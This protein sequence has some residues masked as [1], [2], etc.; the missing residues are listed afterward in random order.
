MSKLQTKQKEAAMQ[1]SSKPFP[2]PGP[3]GSPTPPL[4]G[5]YILEKGVG[6]PCT[7]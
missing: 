6:P 3:L 5:E 7:Q 1:S 2:P 4:R